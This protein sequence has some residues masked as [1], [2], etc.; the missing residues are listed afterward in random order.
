MQTVDPA[1]GFAAMLCWTLRM[2]ILVV[3]DTDLLALKL[4]RAHPQEL[5]WRAML[6]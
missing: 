4:G 3:V 6:P 5:R 2:A 1:A